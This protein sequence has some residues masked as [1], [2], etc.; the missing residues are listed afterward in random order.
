MRLGI[1]SRI[2]EC[3]DCSWRDEENEKA[4]F[5]RARAHAKKKHHNVSIE[6][7]LVVHYNYRV[8]RAPKERS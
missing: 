1:V 7:V 2:A 3:L 6:S 4:I 5:R 8:N